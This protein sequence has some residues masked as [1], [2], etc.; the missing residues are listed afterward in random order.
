MAG[1]PGG[2][3]EFEGRRCLWLLGGRG[4]VGGGEGGEK[5]EERLR[6]G[7]CRGGMETGQAGDGEGEGELSR[8]G[9]TSEEVSFRVVGGAIGPAWCFEKGRLLRISSPPI[10]TKP[11]HPEC[12][13]LQQDR[14]IIAPQP[15]GEIER[16]EVDT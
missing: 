5:G 16:R 10:T 14:S 1:E 11:S 4:K 9:V 12:N 6:R 2:V 3:R 13:W 7:S 8:S 15:G